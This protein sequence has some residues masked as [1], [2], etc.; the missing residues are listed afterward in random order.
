MLQ[1]PTTKICAQTR[2]IYT[3]HPI[4]SSKRIREWEKKRNIS[5]QTNVSK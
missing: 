4:T 3:S 1:K 2:H 5:A